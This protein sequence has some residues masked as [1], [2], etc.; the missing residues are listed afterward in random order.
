[1]RKT[2]AES[3][4]DQKLKR[5]KMFSLRLAT[6]VLAAAALIGGAF[7][8]ANGQTAKTPGPATPADVAKAIAFAI[9][10]NTVKTPGA[11]LTFESATSHDN[12]VEMRYVASDDAGFARLKASVDQTRLVKASYYCK[13][14]RLAYLKLGVV[15][16]EVIATPG[17]SDQIEFTFD[18]S[19]C[20]D[21][22]KP[23]LADAKTLAELALT[24][25]KAQ[26]QAAENEALGKASNAS[27]HL[28]EATAHQG[29]VDERF[30]IP[31]SSSGAKT[32]AN[33]GKI[34][35]VTTGYYCSKFRD[36]ISQ[37]LAFHQFFVLGDDSP[38][39]DFTIDRSNC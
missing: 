2:I 27:V 36:V 4:A 3:D 16:H 18:K 15:M 10:A 9:N 35:A 38:V 31:D 22:P 17:N 29:V 34:V 30:I 33:R 25:A 13:D 26:N 11:A 39:I 5:P 14:S 32:Q 19:S 6:R 20:D 37:G 23:K 1:L 21:L 24:V 8:E 12:V 28:S 7:G